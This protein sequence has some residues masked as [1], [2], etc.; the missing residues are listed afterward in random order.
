MKSALS[1]QI[2]IVEANLGEEGRKIFFVCRR[3]IESGAR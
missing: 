2:E 3:K 1:E